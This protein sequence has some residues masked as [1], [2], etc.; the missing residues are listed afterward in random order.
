MHPQVLQRALERLADRFPV[1]EIEAAAVR[2]HH[3][4]IGVAGEHV[5]PGRPA[6]DLVRLAAE[7]GQAGEVLRLVH[8]QH[9][10]GLG[11]ALGVRGGARGEEDLRERIGPDPG[12]GGLDIRRGIAL[13]DVRERGYAAAGRPARDLLHALEDVERQ[14]RTVGLRIGGVDHRGTH[15]AGAIAQPGPGLR[16]ERVLL[17]QRHQRRADRLGGEREDRVI[18]R[19]AGQDDDGAAITDP[20]RKETRGGGADQPGRLRVGDF[21]PAVPAPLRDEDAV[22]RLPGPAVQPVEGRPGDRTEFEVRAQDYRPVGTLFPA[23]PVGHDFQCVGQSRPPPGRNLLRGRRKGTGG[24]PVRR[25]RRGACI[26]GSTGEVGARPEK[27]RHSAPSRHAR[28]CSGHP[29]PSAAAPPPGPHRDAARRGCPEQ[30][31]A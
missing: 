30:V 18:D 27:R 20:P 1:V 5:V 15:L 7:Q 11:H 13:H 16:Q 31:R 17:G 2:Q 12:E 6:Q 4:E 8:G 23:D 24:G 28:T 10:L 26:H 14:R 22:G 29:R 3:V 21:P 19:G 9:P 25:G